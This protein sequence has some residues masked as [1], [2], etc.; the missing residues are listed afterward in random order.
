[1]EFQLDIF[2]VLNIFAGKKNLETPPQAKKNTLVSGN[3]GDKK[4]LHAGD[5]KLF[6]LINFQE[7]FSFLL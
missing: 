7:I 4:N 5:H 6:F 3:V 2:V 1:M